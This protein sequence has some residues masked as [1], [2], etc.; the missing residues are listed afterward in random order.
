MRFSNTECEIFACLTVV[1]LPELWLYILS[2]VVF[3]DAESET[4]CVVVVFLFVFK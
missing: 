1:L 4:L 2:Y 3:C